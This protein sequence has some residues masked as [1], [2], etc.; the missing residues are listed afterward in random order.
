VGCSRSSP[1]SAPVRATLAARGIAVSE[2]PLD[3]SWVL[4]VSS[5]GPRWLGPAWW[6]GLGLDS[7]EVDPDS[8]RLTRDGA[9]VPFLWL[10]SPGGPGLLFYGEVSA[11]QRQAVE[12]YRL[13][14]GQGEGRVAVAST[15][16]S[17]T[18]ECQRDS[19]VESTYEVDAVFRSTAPMDPPWVWQPLPVGELVTVPVTLTDVVARASVS[20]TLSIWGQSSMPQNPDHHLK[21]LWDGVVVG[22]HRWDGR[23]LERWSVEIP[24]NTYVGVH[25]LGLVTPGDTEAPVEMN[26]LDRVTVGWR[27]SLVLSGSSWRPWYAERENQVCWDLGPLS[28][29]AEQSWL[30][31]V[32]GPGGEVRFVPPTFEEA[33]GLL[34]V[35]QRSGE[36]GWIGLPWEAPAPDGVRLAA[37]M[38]SHRFKDVE[39]LVVAS[40][41]LHA[42]LQPLL[43][44][45]LG[46]G[47]RVGVTTPEAIYDVFGSGAPSAEAIQAMV[48]EYATHGNL[49]SVLLVG[50]ASPIPASRALPGLAYVP[51]VWVRT[52]H[53]GYTPSDYALATGGGEHA[54]V[55]LGRWPVTG[56]TET[57]QLVR[58]TL[59]WVP[60][61]RELLIVD[62]EPDFSRLAERLADIGQDVTWIMSADKDAR[63]RVFRWSN[64][65]PGTIIYVG[66][67]SMQMLGDEK[68][69]TGADADA[70]RN[71]SVVITWACLCA[72]FA[73]PS[74]HSLAEDWL[75]APRGVTAIIGPTGETTTVE[76]RKMALVLQEALNAGDSLGEALQAAWNASPSENVRHGFVLLGDPELRPMPNLVSLEVEHEE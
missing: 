15:P 60:V 1:E 40:E 69:L 34:V 71:P 12:S 50:D 70:W 62:D 41:A 21:V 20:V 42:A 49:R 64:A 27:A 45:R 16:A 13:S 56:T 59:A 46:G 68:I 25:T 4:W 22:D 32:V 73:H 7:E 5:E 47:L 65:G 24:S 76:Q 44:A 55:A 30:A 14:L 17:V 38:D 61:S 52:A 58:K 37:W 35:D 11:P 18:G 54:V 10:D 51:T 31:V 29:V 66:H 3:P 33:S 75:L 53:V 23:G 63:Q 39:Y 6:R 2:P 26:W 43:E 8:I 57:A 48:H 67:G 28:D 72:N 36:R 19:W 74:Y 9:V